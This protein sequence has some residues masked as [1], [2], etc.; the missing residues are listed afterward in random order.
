MVPLFHFAIFF[1]TFDLLRLNKRNYNLGQLEFRTVFL[2]RDVL[3]IELIKQLFI[4]GHQFC[5]VV[6]KS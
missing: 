4:A 2:F 1:H 5:A 3:K 6:K